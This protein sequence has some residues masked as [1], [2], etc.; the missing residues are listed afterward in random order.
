MQLEDKT[1][2]DLF[3]LMA[4]PCPDP[5]FPL[6]RTFRI[7]EG[8]PNLSLARMRSYALKP[9]AGKGSGSVIKGYHWSWGYGQSP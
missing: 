1:P 4:F 6:E 2:H 3:Q 5:V 9:I 7:C 8:C